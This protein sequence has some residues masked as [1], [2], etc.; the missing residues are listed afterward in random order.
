MMML[1]KVAIAIVETFMARQLGMGMDAAME[2][3]SF[4]HHG[5]D[6]GSHGGDETFH[7]PRFNAALEAANAIIFDGHLYRR[8]EMRRHS[9]VTGPP[10]RAMFEDQHP[11]GIGDID[12]AKD[13]L[14]KRPVETLGTIVIIFS[15]RRQRR[16]DLSRQARALR[17][18]QR[19]RLSGFE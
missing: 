5:A 17:M 2:R 19:P 16:A 13:S 7:R 1:D 15:S 6:T 12:R 9:H 8:R 10:W 18:V 14:G 11:V 3:E 4:V